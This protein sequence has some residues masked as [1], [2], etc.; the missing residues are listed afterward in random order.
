VFAEPNSNLSCSGGTGDAHRFTGSYW[1]FGDLN[2]LS[3]DLESLLLKPV[4]D[5]HL[6][7]TSVNFL[8]AKLLLSNEFF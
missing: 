8:P 6:F 4:R 5:N 3:F 2:A 1:V 7:L